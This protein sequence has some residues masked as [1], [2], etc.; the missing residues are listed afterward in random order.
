MTKETLFKQPRIQFVDHLPDLMMPEDYLHS[1]EQKK[2]RIRIT[3][4]EEG[5]EI[6][7]DSRYVPLLEDLLVNAGAKEIEMVLCG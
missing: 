7:G 3:Y 6:L 5:I 1:S 2:I 4:T